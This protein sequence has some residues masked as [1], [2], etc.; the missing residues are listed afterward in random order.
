[1]AVYYGFHL[2]IG[3][4]EGCCAGARVCGSGTGLVTSVICASK[5][6]NH[7]ASP[8]IFSAGGDGS[9]RQTAHNATFPGRQPSVAW[10]RIAAMGG[11]IRRRKVRRLVRVMTGEGWCPG[12]GSNLHALRHE[13]L[14]LACLPI[15]PPGHRWGCR[16][17]VVQSDFET[18]PQWGWV[19]T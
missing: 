13:I 9:K 1:M 16:Q 12:Q 10:E 17:T 14:S 2:R 6:S 15:P 4:H 3:T 8:V 18:R 19:T 7:V 5:R 11:I